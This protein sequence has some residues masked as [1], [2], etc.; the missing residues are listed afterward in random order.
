[1]VDT[2]LL[3]S[4][5]ITFF[6]SAVLVRWWIKRAHKA[7]LTGKDM[8]KIDRR[9][10]AE[11]G[12]FPVL[13]A[14][15]FGLFVFL[16]IRTFFFG[17]TSF[18]NELLAVGLTITLL[19]LIGIIDDILGWKIGLRQWQKPVLCILAS[20]PIMVINSGV[21]HMAIPFFG[22]MELGIIYALIIIPIAISGAANG[23]NMLAG[24]NGLEAG[25]GIIILGALGF[26]VWQVQGLSYVAM[27]AALMIMALLGF[28]MFNRYPANVFPGDTLTYMVGGTIAIVA[29]MGN[30]EKAALILFLPYFVEF[31]LK[32]RGGLKKES[33][34]KVDPDGGLLRPYYKIYGLEHAAIALLQK[35]KRKVTENDVVISLY[36]LQILFV[37]IALLI[38]L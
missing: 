17:N 34:A 6:L 30:V 16:G 37:S 27:I 33:F 25:Q 10:V 12:G 1:M 38:A 22:T 19:A 11:L 26:I 24:Y 18:S 5:A 13:C 9:E 20:L 2:L 35:F 21:S 31:L 7:G 29:I 14:F 3:F 23:F 36:C 28:L 4:L 32:L 8:H 15:L